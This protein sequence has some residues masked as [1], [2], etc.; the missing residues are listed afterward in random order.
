MLMSLTAHPLIPF[1]EGLT[2]EL[3]QLPEI[4][5]ASGGLRLLLLPYV[6]PAEAGGRESQ[7]CWELILER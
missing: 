4:K 5:L 6:E 7:Y 2:F 3:R 1:A